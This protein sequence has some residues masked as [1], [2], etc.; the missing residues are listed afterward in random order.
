MEQNLHELILNGLTMKLTTEKLFVNSATSNETFALRS[1]NGVGIVD[2]VDKFN[3]E[4][5]AWEKRENKILFTQIGAV[6]ITCLSLYGVFFTRS[7]G[8]GLFGFVLA[9]L[10]I[11]IA[12]KIK[13]TARPK[14]QSSVRVMLSGMSRDFEFN[15]KASNSADVAKFVALVEDTLT[16]YHQNN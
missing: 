15:K 3:I 9:G 6:L 8:L 4:L 2:L 7:I 11:F 14:L 1:V 16:S 12:T 13:R 10:V 5:N